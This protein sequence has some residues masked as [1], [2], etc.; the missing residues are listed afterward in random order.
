M[1][2]VGLPIIELPVM[3]IAAL[4]PYIFKL[5]V[6]TMSPCQSSLLGPHQHSLPGQPVF[7]PLVCKPDLYH[8]LLRKSAHQHSIPPF[9][10]ILPGAQEICL[11]DQDTYSLHWKEVKGGQEDWL[12]SNLQGEVMGGD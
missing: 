2:V 11:P 12:V 8:Q 3:V 1:P 9:R 5:S 6:G 7:L 10:A 4:S